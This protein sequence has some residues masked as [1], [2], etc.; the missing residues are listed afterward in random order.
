L[1]SD[2]WK[3]FTGPAIQLSIECGGTSGRFA[4][5]G[6][7]ARIFP[8]HSAFVR[9]VIAEG[10]ATAS[11]FPSGP[12]PNDKLTSKSNDV[13]EYLT[14]GQTEGLGTQSWL[15]KNADPI[16]GVVILTGLREEPNL[17]SLRVR[18]PSAMTDLAPAIIQQTEGEVA[19]LSAQK[20]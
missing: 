2:K 19:V 15:Q 9:E 14:P 16:C 17:I 13:V 12:Y 18:L 10:F 3:G 11:D 20:Q 7:I 1:F 8:S 4:V 5:A 6:T